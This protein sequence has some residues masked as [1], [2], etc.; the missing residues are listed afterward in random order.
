M[1]KQTK[2]VTALILC[3]LMIMSCAST[4]KQVTYPEMSGTVVNISKYGNSYISVKASE[5]E[6]AG[7]ATGDIITVNVNGTS[8]DMPIGTSYSDVDNGS[9]IAKMDYDDDI[10]ELA[11]N[12]GN[13]AGATGSALETVISFSMKD[14]G[15]YADEYMIRHLEKSEE[16]SDYS[17]DAVFANFREVTVGNI[18]PATLYRGCN[19]VYGDAR[20]P[21]AEALVKEAKINTVIN[22]A[23][24]VESASEHFAEAPYYKSLYDKGNVVLLDMAVDFYS[25]LFIEKMHDGLVFLSEH[26]GPYYIHCNEGKDRAGY[27]S[28]VIEALCGGTTEEIIADYMT[29]FENYFKV[30]KGTAQYDAIAKIAQGFL[31]S[32]NNGVSPSDAELS[33][34]TRNYLVNTVKLTNAQVD[35]VIEKLTK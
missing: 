5:A 21:Y 26:E 18:K 16:R 4:Q 13:F 20:A 35:K 29:S 6:A 23:D 10:V 25:P 9:Y 15:G 28:A 1:K 32:L 34:V 27:V 33:D 12:H 31:D 3:T 30:E 2:L 8:I 22:L 24:S 11:I 17:S 14:K 7:Y 19:P